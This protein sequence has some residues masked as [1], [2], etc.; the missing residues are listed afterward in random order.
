MNTWRSLLLIYDAI[1][2]EL[3]D[4]SGSSQC[5]R[6]ILTDTEVRDGI[7]SFAQFPLLVEDLTSRRASVEYEIL[8]VERC[9]KSLTEMSEGMYW[10]S[11]SDTWEEIDRWVAPGSCE[12]IFV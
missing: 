11:P 1:D 3:R 5:F 9:L 6:H 10:P 8:R 2:V 4:R 12:S 7:S